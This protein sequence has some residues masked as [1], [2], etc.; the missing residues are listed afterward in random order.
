MSLT[1]NSS[2]MPPTRPHKPRGLRPSPYSFSDHE[3]SYFEIRP[4]QADVAQR[5][6][7]DCYAAP[8]DPVLNRGR[9]SLSNRD[10]A[11][12][13]ALTHEGVARLVEA[14]EVYI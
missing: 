14:T 9:E 1:Q 2:D 8:L 4:V 3:K 7:M 6:A 10:S 11:L 13:Q 5:E 12:P